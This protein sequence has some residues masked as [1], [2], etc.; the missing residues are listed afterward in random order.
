[1][2]CAAALILVGASGVGKNTVAEILLSMEGS[3][4]TYTR[5]LTTR[6]VRGTFSDE[7]LYVS[8][9]EFLSRVSGGKMLEY[10]R[11]GGKF[12]GTPVSEVERAR[13]EGKIP[14]MI[15]DINGV[16]SIRRD[17]PE[18]PIY[19][20]YL[21]ADPRE[22]ALRLEKRDL[23]DGSEENR[24]KIRMRLRNNREDFRSLAD[25]RYASFDA[26]VEN[27]DMNEC[28]RAVMRSYEASEPLNEAQCAYMRSLFEKMSHIEF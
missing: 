22:I 7:Y 12:Y 13:L 18:L 23:L 5:S 11:Y 16:E 24:H 6:E 25:G 26:F 21:Y 8:E 1:M 20:V 14:L 9:E 28:A 3:P 10:T 17:H 15:L 2:S 19:A 4:F 27:K